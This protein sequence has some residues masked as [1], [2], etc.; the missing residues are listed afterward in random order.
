[1]AAS[2][3]APQSHPVSQRV[4][5][6]V[7]WNIRGGRRVDAAH[8]T[9]QAAIEAIGIACVAWPNGGRRGRQFGLL[10]AFA[11]DRTL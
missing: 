8:R 11:P 6:Q 10:D 3:G 7:V 1:M 4:D 2:R 5:P 9:G